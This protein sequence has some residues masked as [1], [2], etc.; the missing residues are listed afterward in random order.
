VLVV[1]DASVLVPA[2]ADSGPGGDAVRARLIEL[3]GTE[4]MHVVHT[5]TKLEL[6]SSMSKLVATGRLDER[7][8]E[9]ALRD[10]VQLPVV[11]HEVTQSMVARIWEMRGSITP[12][13]AAYVALV[14]RL[15]SE[16]LASACLATADARLQRVPGL[17]I[18]IELFTS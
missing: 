17:S 18:E 13:D 9:R 4:S 5:L 16:G 8:A 1:A 7:D 6:I 10:F 12:Y 14:E 15:G 11:R 3:A 2:L